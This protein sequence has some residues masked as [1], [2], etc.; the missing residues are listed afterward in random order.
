VTGS[1][2]A[3]GL[4]PEAFL[5]ASAGEPRGLWARGERWVAHRGTL[6][7]LN[8]RGAERFASVRAAAASLPAPAAEGERVRLYGGFAFR[9]DHEPEGAWEGFPAALF[10][11][12]EVEL[13]GDASGRRMRVRA[14]SEAR[15]VETTRAALSA[16]AGE[17]RDR[18][19]RAEVGAGPRVAGTGPDPHV[20]GSGPDPLVAGRPPGTG[21]EVARLTALRQDVWEHAVEG[22]LGAIAAGRVSKVVL[23]RTL[24]V[25]GRAAV[26]PVEV[27][28]ALRA[29]NPLTHVF[30]FEPTPG[31]ALLGAA[32]EA[33]ATLRRG[34]FHATAVA[35]SVARGADAGEQARLAAALLASAKDRAEQRVVVEDMVR[36]LTPLARDVRAEAE[37]HVLT[38]ARI[39]HLE[40]EIR[41]RIDEGTAILD[42]VEELHPTP[43]VCGV[44]RE[45]ALALLRRE[46]PFHRG[47]YAGPVGWFTLEGDGHFVPALRT[48][49]GDGRHWRLFAGAGIVEGSRPAAEW[50]ETAIKLEPVRRALAAAGVRFP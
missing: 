24:D 17:L 10:H 47:W 38:L 35:G 50:E 14:L 11:L 28:A 19:L 34:V 39:Q 43:A 5:R 6:A 42:L 13:T 33:V 3:A 16:R 49:V 36:R 46:E 15:D 12:P 21:A 20:A 48:A 18:M 2:E 31:R 29:G 44:P 23:A 26:D 8:G 25:D 9:H 40:T 30:L 27:L 45:G 7:V 37:P 22:I 1:V 41:A 4:E 32:P